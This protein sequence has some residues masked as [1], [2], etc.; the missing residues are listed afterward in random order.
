MDDQLPCKNDKLAVDPL[1]KIRIIE[2]FN[3]VI[4]QVD[5]NAETILLRIHQNVVTRQLIEEEITKSRNLLIDQINL[6][7]KINLDNLKKTTYTSENQ[8]EEI[9]DNLLKYCVYL[10]SETVRSFTFNEDRL[11][12]LLVTDFYISES[13]AKELK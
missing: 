11:G 13:Q 8:F 5:I 9:Q 2:E 10:D 3:E 4:N 12:I 6:I 1:H 7:K